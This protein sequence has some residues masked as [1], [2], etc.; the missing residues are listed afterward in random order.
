MKIKDVIF[1]LSAFDSEREVGIMLVEKEY[2]FPSDIPIMDVIETWGKSAWGKQVFILYNDTGKNWPGKEAYILD[3]P[4]VEKLK[5]EKEKLWKEWL[6]FHG[7][8]HM[9]ADEN[10]NAIWDIP[11]SEK[12]A[13]EKLKQYHKVDKERDRLIKKLTKE[14]E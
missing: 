14:A 10:H 3:H 4:E 1:K 13:E 6:D 12:K 2:Q 9:H 7:A 8:P 11:E 5:I